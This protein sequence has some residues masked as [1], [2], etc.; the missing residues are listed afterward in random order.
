MLFKKTVLCPGCI[1]LFMYDGIKNQ[2][3]RTIIAFLFNENIYT[4]IRS[5]HKNF[6]MRKKRISG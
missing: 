5:T 2:T 6:Q 4:Q 1:I 3:S